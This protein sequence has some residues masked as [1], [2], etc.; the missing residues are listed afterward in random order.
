MNTQVLFLSSVF[1]SLS[2]E[3]LNLVTSLG[4][5]VREVKFLRMD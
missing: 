3:A 5:K 1:G 2:S 4:L